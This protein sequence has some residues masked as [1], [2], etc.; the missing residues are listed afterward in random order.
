M[1]N[2]M[3]KKLFSLSKLDPTESDKKMNLC[4]LSDVY[5]FEEDNARRALKIINRPT[6]LCF[7]V[8]SSLF[9]SFMCERMTHPTLILIDG[10]EQKGLIS[11]IIAFQD[12][13]TSSF[14]HIMKLKKCQSLTH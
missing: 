4:Y 5:D 8:S 2:F 12:L 13:F 11:H 3:N 7:L 14:S 9:K 6:L 10:K 1:K